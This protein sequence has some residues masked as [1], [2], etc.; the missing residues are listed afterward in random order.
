MFTG[1]LRQLWA[2]QLAFSLSVIFPI[3]VCSLVYYWHIDNW[4]NHP[5]VKVLQL[6]DRDWQ[7]A[8]LMIDTEY[9]R[10]DKFTAALGGTN[11]IVVTDSWVIKVTSYDVT[12]SQQ[13]DVRLNI[14]ATDEH[15]LSHLTQDSGQVGV[16]FLNITVENLSK[17]I[18]PF[19]LR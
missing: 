18:K 5:L 12:L 9:R 8:A 2:W 17:P 7:R 11:R 15:S 13:A 10:V 3:S 14:S 19:I 4:S 16:Q 1:F 6:Y